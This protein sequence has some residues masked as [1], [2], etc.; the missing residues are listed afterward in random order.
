MGLSN[1][2][3]GRVT[4]IDVTYQ[5]FNLGRALFLPQRLALIGQGSSTVTYSLTPRLINSSGDA[6]TTYGFGSPIHLAALALFPANNDG[7]GGIPVTVYPL[8]D[9]GAGVPA[10]GS[11]DLAGTSTEQGTGVVYVGGITSAQFTIPSGTAA[12]DA[13][14]LIKTA[15]DSILAQPFLTGTVLAGALPI[16]AKWDGD[17]G[18]DISIDVSDL[19]IAGLTFSTTVM[20]TGAAN[21][22]VDDALNMI[23]NV[24]ETMVLNCMNY[25]DLTTLGKFQAWGEG[26]W[27]NLVKKPAVVA[28]GSVDNFA[29]RTAITDARKDDK[30]NFLIQSIGSRELPFVIA[31]RGLAKDIMPTAND[32]P[33]QNYKGKLTQLQAGI[34]SVQESYTIRNNA[35]K[36]GA[37]TNVLTGSV[38]EL[39]DIVTFYHPAGEPIPAFRYVVDIVK[40]QNILFNCELIFASDDWKGAPLLP[41]G[42]PTTNPT[43]KQPKNARTALGNLADSLASSAIIAEPEFTRANLTVDIDSQ[44]PKRLNWKFPVKLSGN[45]EVISGDILFGFFLSE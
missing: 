5:N 38:A 22:D 36:L 41:D 39:S 42:T 17:S 32:N 11:I 18:N 27:G 15:I 35:M 21:P 24:W 16:T 44:N 7:I 2:A 12:D 37:S 43:A 4:G 14:A 34:D 9:D 3:I 33:A 13:L 29:T 19:D 8:V 1:S 6:G 23:V 20:A 40:L 26:R 10:T 45:T 31:A 25:S 28:V 30:I